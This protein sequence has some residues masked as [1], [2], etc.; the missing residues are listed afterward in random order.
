M[1]V[2]SYLYI[3]LLQNIKLLA[4]SNICSMQCDISVFRNKLK[5]N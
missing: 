3:K 5:L 1:D 4:Y 2:H